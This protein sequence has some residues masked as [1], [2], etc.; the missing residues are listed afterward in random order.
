MR[1]QLELSRFVVAALRAEPRCPELDAIAEDWN[2]T[3]SPRW[4]KRFARHLRRCD[5]CGAVRSGFVP[6]HRLLAGAASVSV[7]AGAVTDVLA[8][9]GGSA[10]AWL[11]HLAGAKVAAALLVAA[12]V[13]GGFYLALPEDDQ[14]RTPDAVAPAPA[15]APT[16]RSSRPASAEPSASPSPSAAGP[17]S[18]AHVPLGP[19]VIKPVTGAGTI[20]ALDGDTLIEAAG[21]PGLAVTVMPGIADEDCLSLRV[22]DG[23]YVRHAS[24]GMMLGSDDGGLLFQMDATFCPRPGVEPRSVRLA[25]FNYPGRF[26]RVRGE[27][28]KLDPEEAGDAYTRETSFVI[29]GQ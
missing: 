14:P 26:V 29:T 19:A 28:L 24:F 27:Q 21:V 13:S 5:R 9:G 10:V 11:G 23:R 8:G 15:P 22:A 4:R 2:G 12:T 6:L 20:V 25:S 16:Q 7:P 1:H 18:T 3:P 17:S